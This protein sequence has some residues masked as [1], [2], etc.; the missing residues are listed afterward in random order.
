MTYNSVRPKYYGRCT[1]CNTPNY[2]FEPNVETC[3]RW[4]GCN[5]RVLTGSAPNEE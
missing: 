4:G 1:R 5:G 3:C 2:T